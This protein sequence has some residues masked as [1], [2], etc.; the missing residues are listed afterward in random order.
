MY[1]YLEENPYHFECEN[2]CRVFFPYSNVIRVSQKSDIPIGSISAGAVISKS[3]SEYSY[4]VWI[5]DSERC[6]EFEKTAEE[7]TEYIMT[8]LLFESLRKFTGY[9]PK[10][11]MLTG[12][13]PVKLL[14]EHYENEGETAAVKGFLE[15]FHISREKLSLMQDTLKLQYPYINALNDKDFCLYVGIPFCPTKCSYCSFVSQS[16]E[17]AKALIDPFFE[18]LLLEITKTAEVVSKLGLSLISVYVG[19]G[20]PTTLSAKQLTQLAQHLIDSFDMSRCREFTIEA[21]R[22]DTIDKEKLYAM[23]QSGVTRISINPQSLSDDVLRQIGRNH[24]AKEVEEVFK[25]AENAGFKSINSDVIVGLPGDDLKSFQHTIDSLINFGATNITIHALALKRASQITGE[26]DFSSH[27]N[28]EL[29]NE[30][31]HYAYNKLNIMGFE[32]YY[33]Y[34]QSRMAGNLENTGWCREKDICSYNIYTMDE[35]V[36]VIACGAGGVSKLKSPGDRRLERIFN[37]KY[38][39]EYISRHHEI[40]ERKDGV[41]RFYEQFCQRIY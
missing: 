16:I 26:E 24:T 2:L 23:K 35:S 40:I 21:G 11:G 1:L 7:K 30:M 19:G 4:K 10:W 18:M 9:F 38:P 22:P 15:D 27:Q 34:R 32:P 3:C 8:N 41:I 29:V 14:R 39:H 37:F 6:E 25:L 31:M 20:T 17:K 13:H 28:Q 33:L 12:I 36:S 5:S